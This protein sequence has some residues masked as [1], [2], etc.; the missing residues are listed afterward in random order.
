MALLHPSPAEGRG[1]AGSAQRLTTQDGMLRLGISGQYQ[2]WD[3][4]RSGQRAGYGG[5]FSGSERSQMS[6]FQLKSKTLA[7]SQ[8]DLQ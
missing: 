8:F 7:F 3:L 4:D 2:A 5:N 1:I 6:M